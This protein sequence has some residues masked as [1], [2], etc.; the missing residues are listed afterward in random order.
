MKID[1]DLLH[2]FKL[3]GSGF[4]IGIALLVFILNGKKSRCNWFPNERILNIIRQKNIEYTP[5][6][7]QLLENKIIDSTDIN[8][9]LLNGDVNFSKS[10]VKNKPCRKYWIDGNI[11]DK[12]ATL[13]VK[14]CDSIA[15]LDKLDIY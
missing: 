9:F 7:N 2:R 10:Q 11:K 1:K 12:K 13:H 3:Y 4:A 6:I 5:N 8:L 14:I 15:Y